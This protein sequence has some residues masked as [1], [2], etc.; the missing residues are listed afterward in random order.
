MHLVTRYALL[1]ACVVLGGGQASAQL[2]GSDPLVPKLESDPRKPPRF[3]TAP[4]PIA[5]ADQP[6]T[7]APAPGAGDTGFDA[8]NSGKKK[9]KPKA[10][11]VTGPA[12]AATAVP[13]KTSPYQTPPPGAADDA[14][15]AAPPGTPPIDSIEPLSP[16]KKRKPRGEPPDPYVPLGIR[17][18]SFDLFPA[19]EFN[20][21]YD[22][23]P[24][25]LTNAQGAAIY[26]VAPELRAQSNWSRHALK[27]HLRG[28]YNWY[29]P[30]Q[31]PTLS[32]P[33]VNGKIDGRVDVT[34]DTRIDLNTHL[35]V[36][37]DNPGSPNLQA[38]LAKFPVFATFGG[39]AGVGQRFNRLDLSLKGTFDRTVYQNSQLT[40]GTTAGNDDRNYN[41][42]GGK[43]RAGYELLPGV[44]P[45]VEA[46]ADNRVHDLNTDFFGYQRDSKGLTGKAGTTFELSRLL[47]GEI[48]LGYTKRTY[49]D[50]RLEAIA[51]LIG[52]ASLIWTASALTTVKL[53][54]ASAVGESTV[55]GVSGVLYRDVGFQI[56]HAFRQWLIGSV[57]LG[58]GFDDYVGLSREDK[59]Y[60]AAAGLTYKL[61]RS[62]QVKGEVRQDWLRSNV[63]G[64]DYSATSFI[65][66]LRWQR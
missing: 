28:S 61:N 52:D 55:P 8:T 44:V 21:G 57:K 34:H 5:Q 22:T 33:F 40:D 63:T 15:A 51:G 27:A 60:S 16:P 11:G 46:D 66:G 39:E 31:T 13:S 43:F 9:P 4:R 2:A 53:T 56:D 14:L 1:A 32:R 25:R 17:V 50:P 41:Q 7:F 58:F 54:G 48:A 26:R 47:T 38:G 23:N 65:A 30:D 35:L 45:F 24:G 20:G 3:Q 49:E 59:R 42:Y 12:A 10:N 36:S 62:W 19:V 64:A 29:S 18:G 37:T 6:T